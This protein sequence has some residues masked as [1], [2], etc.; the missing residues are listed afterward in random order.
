MA[1]EQ[2]LV[3][4]EPNYYK[5][6]VAVLENFIAMEGTDHLNN[7]DLEP[8]NPH[9]RFILELVRDQVRTSAQ[10]PQESGSAALMEQEGRGTY[11]EEEW[12]AVIASYPDT[13]R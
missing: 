10:V 7:V 8:L 6:L 9:E 11:T 12:A 3:T 5:I 1:D 13:S 4:L 2:R